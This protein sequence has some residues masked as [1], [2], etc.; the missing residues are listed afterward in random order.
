[1]ENPAEADGGTW[2][3]YVLRCRNNSL[4]IGMTN[5]LGKRVEKHQLGTGSKFVR[6]WRP[7]ELVK[8]IPCENAEEARRLECDLKKLT[9]KNKLEVLGLSGSGEVVKIT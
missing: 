9:R 3:V 7:F 6:S 5:N 8:T 4:Y 1:M 2:C